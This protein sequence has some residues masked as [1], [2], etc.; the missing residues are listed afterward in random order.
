[1]VLFSS[2]LDQYPDHLADSLDKLEI[3]CL[4]KKI[5]NIRDQAETRMLRFIFMEG[6]TGL[7]LRLLVHL[8]I[9]KNWVRQKSQK[10]WLN[11]YELGSPSLSMEQRS[12]LH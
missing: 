4:K 3:P 1:M 7:L 6:A 11:A 5:G 8:A 10:L 2:S 9:L 12:L